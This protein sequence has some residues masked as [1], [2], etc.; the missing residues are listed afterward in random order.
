MA[1]T[2]PP[3]YSQDDLEKDLNKTIAVIKPLDT[4][5]LTTAVEKFGAAAKAAEDE[6]DQ[7]SEE[8]FARAL[9]I[10]NDFK[11]VA[12]LLD[13]PGLQGEGGE[14]LVKSLQLGKQWSKF[15][16]E[17]VLLLITSVEAARK[18][19]MAAD[20]FTGKLLP[21]ILGSGTSLTEKAANI[22][23]MSEKLRK[24]LETTPDI[25][26]KFEQLQTGVKQLAID[27][28][29]ITDERI[30]HYTEVLKALAA[31]SQRLAKKIRE[32]YV[33]L[34]IFTESPNIHDTL[35]EISP[36][37]GLS[38]SIDIVKNACQSIPNPDLFEQLDRATK[39]QADINKKIIEAGKKRGEILKE[40]GKT[41]K[42]TL[43]DIVLKLENVVERI[44]YFTQTKESLLTDIQS[45]VNT[46]ELLA[47]ISTTYQMMYPLLSKHLGKYESAL[48]GKNG[49]LPV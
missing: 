11:T 38:T 7:D 23:A 24:D 39:E 44:P 16:N 28:G 19:R 45:I 17:F 42:T 48:M 29:A 22:K 10:A 37:W 49:L 30:K 25:D 27:L 35:S 15:H 26:S 47:K 1:D 34:G 12:G 36:N 33:A 18:N 9:S 21:A 8:L 43:D 3:A 46:L 41:I 2:A 14:V 4:R 6:I 13:A 20:E 31:Q 40:G 32:L 5:T